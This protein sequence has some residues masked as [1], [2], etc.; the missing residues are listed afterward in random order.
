MCVCV[1]ARAF[2][3]TLFENYNQNNNNKRLPHSWL[4]EDA[5][6]RCGNKARR[7]RNPQR[8]TGTET[9]PSSPLPRQLHHDLL[10]R[11]DLHHHHKPQREKELKLNQKVSSTFSVNKQKMRGKPDR[12]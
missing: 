11:T 4:P 7:H 3:Q 9:Q 6:H 8:K 1:R 10:Q 12:D 2:V 5:P